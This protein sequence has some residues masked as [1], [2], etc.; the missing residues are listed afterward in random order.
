ME[1]IKT[2]QQKKKALEKHQN[3]AEVLFREECTAVKNELKKLSYDSFKEE[4]TFNVSFNPVHSKGCH[5]QPG[6]ACVRNVISFAAIQFP[7][8][9]STSGERHFHFFFLP[10]HGIGTSDIASDDA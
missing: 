1:V 3:D 6:H 9:A 4:A 2:Q 7:P 8:P 5:S 10:L